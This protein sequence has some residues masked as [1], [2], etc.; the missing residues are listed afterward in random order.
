MAYLM[1][2]C[3]EKIRWICF[4]WK[5]TAGFICSSFW[6][7]CWYKGE[8]RGQEKRSPKPNKLWVPLYVFPSRVLLLY[9]T[10]FSPVFWVGSLRIS[11][12]FFFLLQYIVWPRQ[13]HQRFLVVLWVIHAKW[14]FW[15]FKFPERWTISLCRAEI[16]QKRWS[17]CCDKWST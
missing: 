9:I 17:W 8:T 12:F 7:S 13:S 4:P 16:K 1:Q 11:F 5:P 6:I 2:V 15:S 14:D 3:K 10:S